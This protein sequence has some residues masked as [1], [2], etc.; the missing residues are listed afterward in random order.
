VGQWNIS[1]TY[2]DCVCGFVCDVV[3]PEEE[4]EPEEVE[5]EPE[6][7]EPSAEVTNKTLGEMMD[8][9]MSK[10]RTDFYRENSGSFLENSYT[11]KR[12]RDDLPPGAIGM[13]KAPASD[14]TF[15][16]QAINS[17]QASGF[18]VFTNTD[19]DDKDAYGFAIF[20]S[21]TTILDSYTGSDAFDIWYF[22]SLIDKDLRDCWVYEKVIEK[23]EEDDWVSTY[24]FQCER[25]YD[26]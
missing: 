13:D 15:D 2:P 21:L 24:Y 7:E 10:V 23:N 26:K 5:E 22:P 6:E 16:S 17:I 9:S 12:I 1:G 20:T 4:E 14:V 25:V 11:W 19:T 8:D 18:T 3:E